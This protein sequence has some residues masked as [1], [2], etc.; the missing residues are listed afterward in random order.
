MLT[1]NHLS[2]AA[3]TGCVPGQGPIIRP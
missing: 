2:A 1:F 3:H